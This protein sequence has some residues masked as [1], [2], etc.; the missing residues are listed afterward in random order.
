MPFRGAVSSGHGIGKS[1]LTAW[2]A[3]W[4][5]ATRPHSK[6]TV[7]ANTFTQLQDKTWSSSSG[8]G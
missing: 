7:T 1:T 3:N 8:T 6:G 2:F 5:M 4:V